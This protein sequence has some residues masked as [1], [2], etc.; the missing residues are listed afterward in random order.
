MERIES[1]TKE[2]KNARQET[3]VHFFIFSSQQIYFLCT[4]VSK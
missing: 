4:L 2:V 3:Q 1:L